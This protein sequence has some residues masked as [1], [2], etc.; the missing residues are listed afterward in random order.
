MP[1]TLRCHGWTR[2]N[3]LPARLGAGGRIPQVDAGHQP[4]GTGGACGRERHADNGLI[5]S[6]TAAFMK[7]EC[8]W[9]MHFQRGIPECAFSLGLDC[10]RRGQGH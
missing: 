4:L 2:H 6:A 8:C 9:K 7:S 3:C 10:H 1:E 5:G